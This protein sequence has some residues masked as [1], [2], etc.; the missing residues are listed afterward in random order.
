MRTLVV[1][2]FLL[3]AGC[4]GPATQM[5]DAPTVPTLTFAEGPTVEGLNVTY[6][7]AIAGPAGS[8]DHIGGH[9]WNATQAD[10]TAAFS[11][12][13]GCIH[14]AGGGS[15]PASYAITCVVGSGTH[16]LRGHMR[17]TTDGV[18]TNYW[19]NEVRLTVP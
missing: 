11:V 10:P 8:S 6:T 4:A 12:A 7:L 5:T 3:L 15:F 9:Y 14:V 17:V 19:T 13:K 2:A 1:F 18:A 16:Y